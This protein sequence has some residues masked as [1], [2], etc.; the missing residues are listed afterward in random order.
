MSARRVAGYKAVIVSVLGLVSVAHAAS[1]L[2]VERGWRPVVALAGARDSVRAVRTLRETTQLWGVALQRTEVDAGTRDFLDRA[3][4]SLQDFNLKRLYELLPEQDGTFRQLSVSAAFSEGKYRIA[5]RAD[6]HVAVGPEGAR[7]KLGD[8]SLVLRAAPVST[9][10]GDTNYLMQGRAGLVVG[11]IAWEMVIDAAQEFLRLLSSETDE[12][13]ARPMVASRQTILSR[14]P[15]L[16]REDVEPIATL[17]EAFPRMGN[18]LSSL[19]GVDDLISEAVPALPGVK[20]VRAVLHFDPARMEPRYAKL[21]AYLQGLDKLLEADLRWVD[22]QDRTLATLHLT[23]AQLSAR[24][25]L[26]VKDGMLL[27]SRAGTVLVD[28]PIEVGPGMF[29]YSVRASANLRVLG[30]RTQLRAAR[31]NFEHER[32]ERGMELR[33]NMKQVPEIKVNGAALGI[34]PTGVIDMF[35]P[36]N[37]QGL[38]EQSLS[39]ACHGDSGRGVTLKVRYDRR[40]EGNATLDGALTLE[41]IDNFLVKL[42]FGWFSAHVLPDDGARENSSRLMVDLHQAFTADLERY[43]RA[44][45]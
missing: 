13:K 32:T 25:E 34:L 26:Y 12:P 20:R 37:I 23:S 1:S 33:A 11:P 35:I 31:V 17:W 15:R 4:G 8:A 45:D 43:A 44:V 14:N 40:P 27:P 42:G 10:D 28:Q 7:Q 38:I 24:L 18:L 19:G 41:A 6:A 16:G 3:S 9:R 2:A 29:P 39:I 22:A 30:V 21:A 36:G 5:R